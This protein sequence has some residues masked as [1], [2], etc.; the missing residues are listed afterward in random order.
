MYEIAEAPTPI[1][2]PIFAQLTDK[3][4]FKYILFH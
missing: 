1:E 4:N 3:E 2:R